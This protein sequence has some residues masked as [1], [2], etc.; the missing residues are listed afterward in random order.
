M[1]LI[2][3]EWL[4]SFFRKEEGQTLSEYALILVLVAIAVILILT[5]LGTTLIAVFQR[6]IDALT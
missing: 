2:I 1:F 3:Y 4:R 5:T 6:V